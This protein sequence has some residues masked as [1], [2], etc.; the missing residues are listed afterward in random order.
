MDL[1]KYF[2]PVS[3]PVLPKEVSQLTEKELR[4]VNATVKATI[5]EEEAKSRKGTKYNYY[6]QE[7]RASIGRY[8]AVHGPIRAVEYFSKTM[9]TV[10]PETTARRFKKEYLKEVSKK[11][12]TSKVF[13]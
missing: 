2:K 11:V 10:L 5:V 3:K 8:A 9:K 1:F 6:T 13:A 12:S 7:Q 4:D